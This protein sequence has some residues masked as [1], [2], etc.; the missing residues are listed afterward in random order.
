VTPEVPRKRFGQGNEVDRARPHV[1]H[2]DYWPL[3]LIRRGVDDFLVNHA[4]ELRGGRVLDFGSGDSPYAQ[5]ARSLEI[6]LMAA[7]IEP[8]PGVIAIDPASGRVAMED[9]S[10][11]A[12]LSTQVLEHVA[13]V[14]AYLREALRLLKPGGALFCTTHGAFILHR[15]PTDFRRWTIDGLRHELEL[16]GFV[17]ERVEPKLGILATSTHLRAITFGGITRRIPFT[18]WLRPIIYAFFNARM[19]VE[20]WLTPR[21]V[22]EAHPELLF[23]TA[24]K[25]KP[26]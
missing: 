18:G 16:A 20:E 26:Q 23:A 11:D 15:H 22:M 14:Q 9:E 3:K 1:F 21:S 7:D 8:G 12:V 10:V 4:G 17:V 6:E 2:R 13:D 5:V 24:R 19:A 25:A